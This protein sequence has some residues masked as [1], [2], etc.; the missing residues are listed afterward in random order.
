MTS[1]RKR[2]SVVA[3]CVKSGARVFSDV[4]LITPSVF[5][6]KTGRSTS[7]AKIGGWFAEVLRSAVLIC[8]GSPFNGVFMIIP[9]LRTSIDC[10]FVS[11]VAVFVV[12]LKPFGNDILAL[13][14]HGC[15]VLIGSLAGRIVVVINCTGC[16]GWSDE[17]RLQ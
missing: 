11:G 10:T 6:A 4:V 9:A 13:L 15:F 7:G 2:K 1:H 17:V 8:P 12:L 3:C 5:T 16:Q 14:A